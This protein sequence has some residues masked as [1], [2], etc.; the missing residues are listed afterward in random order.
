[1]T[2]LAFESGIFT[3]QHGEF[4]IST[5]RARLDMDAIHRFLHEEA[6]WSP[7]IERDM[8]ERAV[9]GSLPFGA[10]A[11]DGSLAGF[12]RVVTDG[13]AFAYLRDVFVLDAHRGRGL[14]R[15]ISAAALEHPDLASIRNWM[16]ATRDAHGVYA[17]LGFRPL[18]DPSL[19]MQKRRP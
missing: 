9:A 14:G 6:Y 19:Y 1:M 4:L 12:A 18:P 15:A 3:R 2:P 5:D 13:A 16:L 17:A 7:G 11:A 8:V 10:Y